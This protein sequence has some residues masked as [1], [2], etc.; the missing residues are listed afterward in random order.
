MKKTPFALRDLCAN[1]NKK[2]A[3]VKYPIG[4]PPLKIEMVSAG[5]N[6]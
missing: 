1:L 5:N 4:S 6:D 2:K 3:S